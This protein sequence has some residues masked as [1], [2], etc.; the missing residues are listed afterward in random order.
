MWQALGIISFLVGLAAF[1]GT[2]AGLTT[3]IARKRWKVLKWSGATCC[4]AFLL[5]IVAIALDGGSDR[6]DDTG[7][8][9]SASNPTTSPEASPSTRLTTQEPVAT[10]S[11]VPTATPV[12][13]PTPL[14]S[15]SASELAQACEA[16]E[17]AAKT[18]YEEM[19][20]LI[21][22]EVR[23][24]TDARGKYDVKLLTGDVWTDVVC[25]VDISGVD[26]V[27]ALQKGQVVTVLGKIKGKGFADIVVDQCSI[28]H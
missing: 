15:V 5:L 8:P 24:I 4:V 12:P 27:I 7:P 22:G 11:P 9:I 20:A 16:N 10:A 14:P 21:T 18:K 2:I 19:T 23:S 28:Q 17:V 25:K 6:S 13:T 1:I 26:S 3:G